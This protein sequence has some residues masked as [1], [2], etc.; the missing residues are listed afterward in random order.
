[1]RLPARLRH[2]IAPGPLEPSSLTAGGETLR[3]VFRRHAQARR[4][5]LRL[6]ASGSGVLVTV[7]K[8]ISRARALEF[9]ERSSS[10][11]ERQLLTRGSSIRLEPG[12]VVPLRGIGHEIREAGSLRGVVTADPLC[13]IITVPGEA[14]HL[15]RRLLAFLKEEA[16]GDLTAA[17]EKYA[18]LMGV[19][20]RRITLRD[21]RSR[22][23]SCSTTALASGGWC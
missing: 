22:W 17:S 21:Q 6:D 3:V 4:L 19:S 8:G 20:F 7:P 18:A 2:A 11:I 10:W 12:H 23:G 1:M 9:V 13:R 15:R 5:V 14:P 16:R